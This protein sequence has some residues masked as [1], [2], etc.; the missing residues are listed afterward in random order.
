MLTRITA[1]ERA[2]DAYSDLVGDG[3][4]GDGEAISEL[5]LSALMIT[6]LDGL[7]KHF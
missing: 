2:P 3:D 1:G 6:P 5:N 7:V 4:D